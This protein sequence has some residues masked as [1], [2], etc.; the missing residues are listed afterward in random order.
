V[1]LTVEDL[2]RQEYARLVR[3]LS[4]ACG[5]EDAAID[6]VQDAFVQANRHWRKVRDYDDPARWL[7]RVALNRLADGHR[8]RRRRDAGVERIGSDRLAR[9]ADTVAAPDDHADGSLVDLRAAIAALPERQRLAV[10]LH[11]LADLG[12]DEVAELLGVS[13][14]TVKSQLHDARKNLL[15]TLEVR[16]G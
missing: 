9:G 14:G 8:N 6:A 2:F 7:R 11:Y 12:I 1:H 15:A 4:V 5:S 13:A 16:D 10:S 3:A